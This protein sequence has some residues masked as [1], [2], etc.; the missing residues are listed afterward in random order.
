MVLLDELWYSRYRCRDY[1]CFAIPSKPSFSASFFDLRLTEL[2]EA[3]HDNNTL[4]GFDNP[5]SNQRMA[6]I[7]EN[8]ER[9]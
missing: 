5:L 8:L 7:A 3:F 1:S 4:D 2:R 9:Q 6:V